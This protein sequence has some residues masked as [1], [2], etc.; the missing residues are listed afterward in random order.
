MALEVAPH[1]VLQLAL[2]LRPPLLSAHVIACSRQPQCSTLA[3]TS[4][5]VVHKIFNGE[6]SW[7]F[8]GL[9]DAVLSMCQPPMR[10]A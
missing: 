4:S 9:S 6:R 8:M 10:V 2:Q 3:L 7:C 5:A 1:L